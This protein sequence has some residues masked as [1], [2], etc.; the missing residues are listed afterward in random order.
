M[1][2]EPN[3]TE[4]MDMRLSKEHKELIEEAAALAGVSA[5]ALATEAIVERAQAVI[6]RHRRTTLSTRDFAQFVDLL[7]S[8]PSA[9]AALRR[10]AKRYKA[11]RG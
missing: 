10:A 7:E 6:E 11:R 2:I 1:P 5:T 3:K 4:R 9:N 8:P